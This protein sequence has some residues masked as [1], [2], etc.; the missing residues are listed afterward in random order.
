[1]LGD[2]AILLRSMQG[3][4]IDRESDLEKLREDVLVLIYKAIELQLKEDWKELKSG[5]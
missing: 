4:Y 2:L 1:M 3:F 5:K